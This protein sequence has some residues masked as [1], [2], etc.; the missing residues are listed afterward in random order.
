[1]LY[2]AAQRDHS[3][4]LFKG[5]AGNAEFKDALDETVFGVTVLH[6]IVANKDVNKLKCFLT[7]NVDVNLVD[8]FD[9]TPLHW[10]AETNALKC[11]EELLGVA[12]IQ[13]NKKNSSRH[14]ALKSATD[15]EMRRFLQKH[16][17]TE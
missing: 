15:D 4:E 16:G 10:A 13:K 9:R 8:M 12:S 3:T 6:T 2:Y 1:M 7:Q 14:T 17:C 11:A 5:L